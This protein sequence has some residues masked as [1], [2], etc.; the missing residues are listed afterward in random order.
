M[1]RLFIVLLLFPVGLFSQTGKSDEILLGK[2]TRED[3]TKAPYNVWFDKEYNDYEINQDVLNQ[4]KRTRIKNYTITIFLG[5]WCSD[6][7]REV[8]R[9][10]KVLEKAGVPSNRITLVA[11]NSGYGVHKQ[12]TTGEEKGK[13]I[14][15]VPTFVL[16]R[17]NKEVNRIVEFPV[18]SLERDLLSIIKTPSSYV[19]NYRSY[20]YIIDWIKNGTLTDKNVSVKGLV[21]QIKSVTRNAGEITSVAYVLFCQ[22]KNQEAA[23]LCKIATIIYPETVNYYTCAMIYAESGDFEEAMETIKKYLAE[24]SDRE[25][26]DTALEL[27]DE[28]KTKLK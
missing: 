17:N 7:H 15:R 16:S 4:L 9:M 1:R 20:P 12:S 21:D 8:P 19:P 25:D 6:S 28:I 3:L 18:Q 5:T 13:N 10:I 22:G 27:Y 26:I 24:S 23:T 14:F 2:I 11:L